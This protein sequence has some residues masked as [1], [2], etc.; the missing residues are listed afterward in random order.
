MKEFSSIEDILDFAMR[1]EQEAVDFYTDLA[2]KS[3]N[4]QMHDVFSEFALEEMKHKSRLLV[5][6]ENKSLVLSGETVRD[7]KIADYLVDV[8]ASPE[9]TYADALVLAMKKEKNAFRLYMHLSEQ[10]SDPLM[11]GLFQNLAQEE[12]RHKLR[13]EVEYDEYILKEN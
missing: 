9:M 2:A 8:P 6:K 4:K 3:K 7:M 5:I 1:A 11:K 13:F 10:I 12:S